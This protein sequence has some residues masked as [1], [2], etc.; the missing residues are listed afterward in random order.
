MST[1]F[2]LDSSESGPQ[3]EPMRLSKKW[4]VAGAGLVT[5]T[6]VII[7]ICLAAASCSRAPGKKVFKF[8]IHI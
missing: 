8:K 2:N 4:I 6:V 1:S 3:N 7:L 5:A